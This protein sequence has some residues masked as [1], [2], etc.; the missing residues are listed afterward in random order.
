M[1]SDPRARAQAERLRAPGLAVVWTRARQRI[2]RDATMWRSGAVSIAMEDEVQRAEIE[3]LL[4]KP[5]RG[6]RARIALGALDEALRRGPL[7]V[8]LPAWL[9]MLGP[10]LR[11]KQ[12]EGSARAARLDSAVEV[13]RAS[14]HAGAPWFEAW[15]VRMTDGGG[16]ARLDTQGRLAVVELAVHV[17]DRFPTAGISRAQLAAE[18]TG[19]PKALD[20]GPLGGMVLS[21]L[22]AWADAASTEDGGAL[23]ERFDVYGDDLASQV[24]V[25]GL[26]PRGD[27]AL[28]R[29]LCAAASEG[30][31]VVLTRRDVA[32]PLDAR[33]TVVFA[34]ENPSVLRAAAQRLG[35]RCPP[36]LCTNGWPRAAFWRL[37]DALVTRGA[38]LHYHGDFDPAGVD[39]ADAVLRR[40]SAQPWRMSL[41]DYEAALARTPVM[42]WRGV[43][44]PR[45]PWDTGLERRMVEVAR[46]IYEEHVMDD[47]LADLAEGRPA[48]CTRPPP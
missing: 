27:D 47:L 36:L 19:D 40:L 46:A 21:A 5:V 25:L 37:A 10:P 45:A 48:H 18:T 7:G 30:H 32:R 11:D 39:I 4:G 42:R 2:E 33:A 31:P 14:R 34:C 24:L 8:S 9:A 3:A 35:N 38:V 29:W 41:A 44:A 17:L 26:R 20:D 13:L 1:T 23:W 12:R 16:L 15:L 6:A 22:A 43:L 28:S